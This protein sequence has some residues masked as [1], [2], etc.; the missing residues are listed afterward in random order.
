MAALPTGGLAT[1]GDKN[2]AKVYIWNNSSVNNSNNTKNSHNSPPH[3]NDSDTEDSKTTEANSP[4]NSHDPHKPPPTDVSALG[5][6]F[7]LCVLPDHKPQVL[8]V[9][10]SF[11]C[12]F[13]FCD[14]TYVCMCMM[15]THLFFLS[16]RH[17]AFWLLHVIHRQATSLWL[18]QGITAC[19]W[20]CKWVDSQ[21]RCMNADKFVLIFFRARIAQ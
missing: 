14:H 11:F 3:S 5:Y 1:G 16:A 13:V 12:F 20:Y 8:P 6:C 18:E 4:H 15:I 9:L 19:K 17:Y 2:D 10:G 21:Y 7:A